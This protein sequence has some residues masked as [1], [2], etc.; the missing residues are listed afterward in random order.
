MP[1]NLTRYIE[2]FDRKTELLVKEVLLPNNLDLEKLKEVFRVTDKDPDM[3]YGYDVNGEHL[4]FIR[5]TFGLKLNLDEY[6]YQI[7]CYNEE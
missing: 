5:Q 2:L 4:E 6:D 3:I 7:C 1:N